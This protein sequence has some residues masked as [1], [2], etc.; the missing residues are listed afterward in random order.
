M[1]RI[2]YQGE[3]GSNSEAAAKR[4]VKSRG[5]K[6]GEY[7]LVPLVESR[8]VVSNLK[9]KKIDYGVVAT[10]NSCAGAVAETYEA[11][12]D[13][14]FEFV[15][16]IILPVHHCVFIKQ[17]VSIDHIKVVV[18]HIQALKQTRKTIQDKFPT[19]TKREVSDTAFAARNLAE[20]ILPDDCAV[21]CRKNAGDEYNLLMICENIED[22]PNNRT[23]FRVFKN[24]TIDYSEKNRPSFVQ[25]LTY[26][27]ASEY[28]MSYIAKA[29]LILGM[30]I[31]I[32][33]TQH[34]GQNSFQAAITVGGYTSTIIIFLTSTSFRSNRRYKSLAGY[35]KYYAIS[36]KESLDSKQKFETPRIVKIEEDGNELHLTGVI[37]DKENVPM[38]TSRTGEVLVSFKGKKGRLVYAYESP[39]Q[40]RIQIRGIAYLDWTL[41]YPASSVNIMRGEYY[42]S[43]TG[44]EGTL[45]Y[46]RISE[47][48]YDR[49]RHS[50]FL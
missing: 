16:T 48:E 39:N 24:P 50:T 40:R 9:A 34:F 47:A 20:G 1:V 14:Y 31:A 5:F 19:W 8:Y 4:F 15:D 25:W 17:G 42:G 30:I 46:L 43:A 28:G 41:K 37:C 12:K 26:Q 6:S 32:L 36:N 23:E 45:T 29:I 38:F 10:R 13:E 2:G 7:K 49:H 44:D 35:W 11:I 22:D 21:I 27:F 3:S 33:L 18:S